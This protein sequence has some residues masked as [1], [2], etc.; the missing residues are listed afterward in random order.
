LHFMF[1]A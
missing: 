1:S